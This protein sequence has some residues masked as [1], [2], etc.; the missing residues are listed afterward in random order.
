MMKRLILSTAVAVLL[1]VGLSSPAG[2]FYPLGYR[3]GA[4]PWHG[5]YY[6]PAE[7]VPVPLVVPPTACHQTHLN[8]SV[9]S[10]RVTRIRPQFQ[11]FDIGPGYY[12]P[13]GFQP[14]PRWPSSTDQLGTYYIRAPR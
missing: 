4:V 7:G 5:Q 12:D 13:R 10:E 11:P 14:T 6:S 9:P 2:A 8:S 1:G 3:Y